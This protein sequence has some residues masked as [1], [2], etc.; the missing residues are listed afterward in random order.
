MSLAKT[1]QLYYLSPFDIDETLTERI[2]QGQEGGN[3]SLE[4]FTLM[5]G[6]LME[7]LILETISR[8]IKDERIIRSSQHG[9]P[10]TWPTQ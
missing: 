6:K 5:P 3:C 1:I 9:W 10:L 7:Q 2:Q 8:H 4:S